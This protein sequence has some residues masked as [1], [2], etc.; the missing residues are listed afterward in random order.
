M[1]RVFL[2]KRLG[3]KETELSCGRCVKVEHILVLRLSIHGKQQ[4]VSQI[5]IV[6]QSCHQPQK[7]N[8]HEVVLAVGGIEDV[9]RYLPLKKY[10]ALDKQFSLPE[11]TTGAL[12]V[13]TPVMLQVKGQNQHYYLGS[14]V[15]RLA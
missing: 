13:Y 2:L 12:V 9:L 10:L 7:K 8:H 6:E 1:K 3:L 4:T 14:L 15:E 5:E 11:E